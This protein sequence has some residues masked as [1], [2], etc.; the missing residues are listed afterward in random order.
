MEKTV[1]RKPTDLIANLPW[2][3]HCCNFY[4]TKADL[5]GILTPYFKAGLLNNEL[6]LWVTTNPHRRPLRHTRKG[7]EFR[8]TLDSG[9]FA[10]RWY[11]FNG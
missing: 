9:F 10:G 8:R 3:T 5:L 7:D 1:A 6:C 11:T 2:G 4:K